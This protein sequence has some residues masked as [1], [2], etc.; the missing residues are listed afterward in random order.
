MQDAATMI[1]AAANIAT[2][3]AAIIVP[4]ALFI[5]RRYQRTIGSRRK[6]VGQ[7]DKLSCNVQTVYVDGL[8]GQP[9]FVRKG[10]NAV[11]RVYLT[12][13]AYVQVVADE[14]DS[15]VWWAVTTTDEHFKPRFF[16]PPMSLNEDGWRVQLNKS[17]FADL[18]SSPSGAR[19]VVGARRF[20]FV[21]SYYFGNPGHYQR[22]LVGHN[23]A[24]VGVMHV[25]HGERLP[26]VYGDL[27][28]QS[29]ESTEPCDQSILEDYASTFHAERSGTVVN[30][31]GV[32][33]PSPTAAESDL[34]RKWGLGPD[35][36]Y[37]R[38]RN[39]T[40]ARLP[41]WW[42][43]NRNPLFSWRMRRQWRRMRREVASGTGGN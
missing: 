17:N 20:W 14:N 22:Y 15:V 19:W 24:G 23:D 3:L 6:L 5:R 1:G 40:A 2:V 34:L 12:P 33:R 31:F 26:T 21:E 10:D 35:L 4:F 29:G 13:H 8:F 38:V 25:A 42:W 7:I 36:D 11:E 16:L 39:S 37:I 18:A 43:I 41:S 32:M 27:V 30:T 28:S 9:L